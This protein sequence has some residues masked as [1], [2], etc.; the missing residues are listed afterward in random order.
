M[1]RER[2]KEGNLKQLLWVEL[3]ILSRKPNMNVLQLLNLGDQRLE[4][5][6]Y[7]Q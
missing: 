1:E 5:I 7:N 2:K 3:V 4:V 6:V